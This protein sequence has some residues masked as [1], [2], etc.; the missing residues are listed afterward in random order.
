[1]TKPCKFVELSTGILVVEVD[2]DEAGGGGAS[3]TG[4]AEVGF[5]GLSLPA[6]LV[7]VV[8]DVVEVGIKLLASTE[9]DEDSGPGINAASNIL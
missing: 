8:T 9:S 4:G 2:D 6:L 5:F 3:R 1:M 7:P